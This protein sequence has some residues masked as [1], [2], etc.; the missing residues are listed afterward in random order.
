MPGMSRE[1][2]IIRDQQSREAGYLILMFIKPY[3]IN[4]K[5]L[6]VIH[7]SGQF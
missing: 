5:A 2:F 3:N 6:D 4:Y 7:F 1:V